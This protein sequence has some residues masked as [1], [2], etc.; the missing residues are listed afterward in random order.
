MRGKLKKIILLIIFMQIQIAFS[1]KNDFSVIPLI[2]ISYDLNL[3]FTFG[4]GINYAQIENGGI[5][6]G[7]YSIY[8]IS[9][10]G[11]NIAIGNQ[12]GVGGFI[13]SSIAI[14]RMYLKKQKNIY[15]GIQGNLHPI[16]F[17]GQIGLM[18]NDF[19]NIY[20]IKNYR[21]NLAGGIGIF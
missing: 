10:H 20:S 17:D 11:N 5:Y 4:F 12:A 14:N 18:L 9:K 1:S 7:I 21:L 8:T 2:R 15:W 19:R 3:G 16:I 6:N 13:S